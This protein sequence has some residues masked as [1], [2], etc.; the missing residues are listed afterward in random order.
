MELKIERLS[1][2]GDGIGFI[3]GKVVFVPKTVPGDV[4]LIKDIKDYKKYYR[5]SLDTIVGKSDIR[6]DIECPYYDICG[7]CQIMGI[8]YEKQLE[9]KKNKVVNIF[10]KYADIDINPFIFGNKQ[11]KYRNKIILHVSDGKLGLVKY[12]SHGFVNIDRCLLVSDKINEVIK[13]INDKL[14]LVDVSKIMLREATNGDIMVKFY[15]DISFKQVIGSLDGIVKSIY[16]DDKLVFGDER[17]FSIL[18]GFSFGI[19]PESFFQVNYEGMI[20]IY[21]IILKYINDGDRI[22]D[23]YCGSG[24][25][26][27]YVSSKCSS[28]FGVEINESAVR[29]ANLNKEINGL[30]NVNFRCGNVDSIIDGKYRCDTVIVDPPRGGLNKKTRDILLDVNSDKIIYVSCDAITLARDINY[31][32]SKYYLEDITL[33]DMFPNT[34][35]VES[36]ACLKLISD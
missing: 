14:D 31:L 20:K 25:I 11:F 2:N 22:L 3:D 15:G 34:Y 16:V 13:I 7:G 6:C 19:S 28:I 26:G 9:Y 27:I 10:K 32:K 5:G 18:N 29:D 12:H 23:L 36:V 24:S 35:H 17:I 33:I 21:D 4:I 1:D 30:D 8:S